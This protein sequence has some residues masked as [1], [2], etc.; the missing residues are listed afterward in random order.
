MGLGKD[1]CRKT[2]L[3]VFC[4]KKLSF[5]PSTLHEYGIETTDYTLWG[6]Q[7]FYAYFVIILGI[8]SYNKTPKIEIQHIRLF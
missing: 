8:F 5:P 2:Q 1:T 6:S 4:Q 7:S 3:S